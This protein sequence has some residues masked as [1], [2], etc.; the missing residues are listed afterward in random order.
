M[1]V[2]TSCLDEKVRGY[3]F[4]C[5][6]MKLLTFWMTKTTQTDNKR[7]IEVLK[8]SKIKKSRKSLSLSSRGAE[9]KIYIMPRSDVVEVILAA[10]CTSAVHSHSL[11]INSHQSLFSVIQGN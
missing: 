11:V 1:M 9:K 10:A 5:G 2:A 7:R 8:A 6:P 4:C 3:F